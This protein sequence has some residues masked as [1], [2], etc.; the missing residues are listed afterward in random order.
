M[1]CPRGGCEFSGVDNHRSAI[2]EVSDGEAAID[3]AYRI[4]AE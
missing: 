1:Q 2:A 3:P 4:A